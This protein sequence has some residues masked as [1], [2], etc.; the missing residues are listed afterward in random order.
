MKTKSIL[1][2]SS[3][4]LA[5]TG[6]SYDSN[7][8][9]PCASDQHEDPET[10]KC[11]ANTTSGK[12]CLNDSEC[13]R[14]EICQNRLCIVPA[15][16][17]SDQC[18]AHKKCDNYQCVADGTC[19]NDTHCKQNLVC[20]DHTCVVKSPD[21]LNDDECDGEL[22]CQSG[23][24]VENSLKA[25][26][27]RDDCAEDE[28]CNEVGHCV[29]KPVEC[30]NDGECHDGKI[31][32]DKGLCIAKTCETREDCDANQACLKNKCANLPI[33]CQFD[34]DC[35]TDWL[36][37]DNQC[38]DPAIE[39]DVDNDC[40]GFEICTDAHKCTL[41]CENDNEC[42]GNKVCK[43]FRCKYEC[44]ADTDC[45]DI[46]VCRDNQCAWECER[47]ETCGDYM[48]CEDHQCKPE[49]S[50]S[51]D[52]EGDLVC[53]DGRCAQCGDSK[54]CPD[55]QV[56]QNY[57]CESPRAVAYPCVIDATAEN[58]Y[59]RYYEE[60]DYALPL[61]EDGSVNLCK[62][63]YRASLDDIES[64]K[65]KDE[66]VPLYEPRAFDFYDDGVDS[67]CDGN[68]Y[69]L[70]DVVFVYPAGQGSYEGH[71]TYDG[72]Y[73]A[74]SNAIQPTDSLQSALEHAWHDIV[75]G[76][77]TYKIAS[78]IFVA[79][80][81]YGPYTLKAPVQVPAD[82]EN[83]FVTLTDVPKLKVGG[84]SPASAWA[85][86]S[87]L[88]TRKKAN[89]TFLG[90]EFAYFRENTFEKAAYRVYGGF[91]RKAG[92]DEHYLNWSRE[93]GVKSVFERKVKAP[94]ESYLSLIEPASTESPISLSLN[95]L[96]FSLTSQATTDGHDLTLIGIN[97]GMAGCKT[98]SLT[99]TKITIT[100]PDGMD[101]TQAA[102]CTPQVGVTGRDGQYRLDSDSTYLETAWTAPTPQTCSGVL[103]GQG[104]QA[105]H[106]QSQINKFNDVSYTPNTDAQGKAG[107]DG[108]NITDATKLVLAYGG[109][110]GAGLTNADYETSEGCNSDQDIDPKQGQGADGHPGDQG[111]NGV[112]KALVLTPK[113]NQNELYFVSNRDTAT[114]AYGSVG[115]PGGGGGGGAVYHIYTSSTQKNA[116]IAAGTG[117]SGG[118]GGLGGMP[119]GTGASAVGMLITGPKDQN[120]L[121]SIDNIQINVKA[122]NGGKGQ[123]GCDG[124][125]GGKGGK[126]IG[127]ADEASTFSLTPNLDY[128]CLKATA[129]GQGG[130][131]GGGGA[132]AGGIAGNA[133]AFLFDCVADTYH[134]TDQCDQVTEDTPCFSSQAIA[135]LKSC[136]ITF[137]NN[138][139]LYNTS[140]FGTITA[141]KNAD[142]TKANS[143]AGQG[144]KAATT[145]TKDGESALFKSIITQNND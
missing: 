80:N 130:H 82:D 114:S 30:H 136:G 24:C 55:D 7:S 128:Q 133:Y 19:D 125:T 23:K 6:C 48:I 89:N 61:N 10:G 77:K 76:D 75:I 52:C 22:V 84:L 42:D 53:A 38:K 40:K 90:N 109:Q 13:E 32:N 127:Y 14:D 41:E 143:A 12:S 68:D 110:G 95:N 67:N 51:T 71:D 105:G 117:G 66:C 139:Y 18:G 44:T 64:G 43:Y 45:D 81:S 21:C 11:V 144:N 97:C 134:V 50:V 78:D 83:D 15:C 34:I 5:L 98:L 118:C 88:V 115:A 145:K 65:A 112:Q 72:R 58:G 69:D 27:T 126:G 131:G 33:A 3:L 106:A 113:R 17:S 92:A 2:L 36:C 129:G 59:R 119:G 99:D 135:T 31:C 85:L 60:T 9:T 73:H 79:T 94:S 107:N 54:D 91:S 39:C 74:D 47:D 141:G 102:T 121:I 16:V 57:V 124:V 138:F 101:I 140:N 49:C 103:A 25:C 29:P 120:G 20:K 70:N 137:N 116:W 100:A 35:P 56:C 86:H 26:Q 63:G 62:L 93:T 123:D 1:I 8:D 142:D 96:E 108:A 37:N 28:V 132:G 111:A 87:T 46:K 4:V 104:G 122:G